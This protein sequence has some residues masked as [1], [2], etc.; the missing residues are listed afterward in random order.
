MFKTMW[1]E[2][3]SLQ[4]CLPGRLPSRN[5]MRGRAMPLEGEAVLP[6]WP[7]SRGENLRGLQR[8]TAAAVPFIAL[9]A[10]LRA[11]ASFSHRAAPR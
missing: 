3:S 10:L 1:C 7:Q 6:L 8:S 11:G 9:F 4:P 5:S 2:E